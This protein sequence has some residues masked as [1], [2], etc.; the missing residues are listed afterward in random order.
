MYLSPSIVFSLHG[1][2]LCGE[3]TWLSHHYFTCH[4]AS[5]PA[6]YVLYISGLVEQPNTRAGIP[7]IHCQV[8]VMDF[9]LLCVNRRKVMAEYLLCSWFYTVFSMASTWY[10][11]CSIFVKR[12]R[13]LSCFLNQGYLLDIHLFLKK[14]SPWSKILKYNFRCRLKMFVYH[15]GG[16]LAVT[17]SVY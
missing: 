16:K 17:V 9:F 15:G 7:I 6:T 11:R 14:K 4:G 5:R 3:N 12:W 8:L 1:V 10:A 13:S 2:F